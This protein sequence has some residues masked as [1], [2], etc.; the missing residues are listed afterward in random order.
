MDTA[1]SDLDNH[2][3]GEASDVMPADYRQ[4]L[5]R[6]NHLRENHAVVHRL[7]SLAQYCKKAL[8][9]ELAFHVEE[10]GK[11]SKIENMLNISWETL[12]K[13]NLPAAWSSNPSETSLSPRVTLEELD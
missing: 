3:W 10:A 1:S 6:N 9:L 5:A 7:V 8:F 13:S 2:A 11:L 12:H 4:V